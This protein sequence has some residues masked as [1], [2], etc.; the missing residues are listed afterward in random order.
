V[1]YVHTGFE[2][3]RPLIA[4]EF[5]LIPEKESIGPLLSVFGL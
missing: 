5:I 1:F 4:G 3:G 2:K